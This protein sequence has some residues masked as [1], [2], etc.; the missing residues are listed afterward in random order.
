MLEW[1]QSSPFANVLGI[2]LIVIGVIILLKLFKNIAKPLIVILLVVAVVLIF[3]NVLD[4]ALITTTGE[5]LFGSACSK[6]TSDIDISSEITEGVNGFL[7]GI[8]Q[9]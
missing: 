3:F 8:G 5:K 1:F 6:I 9:K 4:I 7:S 2:I